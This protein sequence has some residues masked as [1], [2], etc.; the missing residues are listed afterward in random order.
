MAEEQTVPTELVGELQGLV[1]QL[2]D[3]SA[4]N[5][6]GRAIVRKIEAILTE[7]GSNADYRQLAESEAIQDFVAKLSEVRSLDQDIQPG[8]IMNPKSPLATKR[9]WTWGDLKGCETKTFIPNETLPVTWNGLTVYLNAD[10]ETTIPIYHYETYMEHRRLTRTGR[11][12]AEY[13]AHQRAHVSDPSM[14]T[15]ESAR[16]RGAATAGHYVPGGGLISEGVTLE[17]VQGEQPA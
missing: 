12:H 9:P 14:I 15:A 3:A 17:E 10:V 1:S 6:S 2:Q 7:I 16:I 5:A 11:E 4:R 13:L 8:Q